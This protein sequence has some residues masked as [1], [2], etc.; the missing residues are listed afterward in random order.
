MP[1]YVWN[2]GECKV[3][4]EVKR[5]IDE[6]DTPPDA[7]SQC[8]SKKLSFVIR[9]PV[10]GVKGFILEGGGWHDDMYNGRRPK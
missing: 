4:T 9:P 5:G 6:M 3:D 1:L 8:G 7:C 10:S 2:C